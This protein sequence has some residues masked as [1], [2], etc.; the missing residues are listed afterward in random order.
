MVLEPGTTA[1]RTEIALIERAIG[2]SW[3][4]LPNLLVDILTLAA[5]VGLGV[6]VHY[7]H[8]R[9]LLDITLWVNEGPK[10]RIGK[11]RIEGNTKTQDRV[12]RR[13]LIVATSADPFMSW[14]CR[15]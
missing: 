4:T 14:N 3:P 13:E 11:I 1:T 7:D 5:I 8:E 6:E 10:V 2:L 15:Q 12:I 9:H